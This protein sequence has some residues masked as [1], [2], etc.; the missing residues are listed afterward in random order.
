[1]MLNRCKYLFLASSAACAAVTNPALAQ[2]KVVTRP[3]GVIT[4]VS[5][6]SI[7]ARVA[8]RALSNGKVLVNDIVRRRVLLFDES[9]KSYKV[10]I[11]SAN[12]GG[13]NAAIPVSLPSAQLI[14]YTSDSTLY[15]DM[16]SMSLLVLDQTGKVAHVMA[17][18]RPRDAF[19]LGGGINFGTPAIDAKG[20]LV[21]RGVI[22]NLPKSLEPGATP[23]FSMPEQP[24]SAPIVRADFDTRKV[25]TLITMKVLKPGSMNMVTDKEGNMTMKITMNPVD[26]GDE[27]AMISDGSIAIVR[28]HDYHIDWLDTDGTRRSTAKMPF[29]WRR[30]TDERK[31]FMIDSLRPE[32]EKQ[33]TATSANLPMIPTAN[34]M[35]K[36]KIAFDFLPPAKMADYEPSVS[37]GAVRADL[38]NNVWILPRTAAGT[39]AGGV[40]YDVVNRLGEVTERVQ[41]PKGRALAGFGAGGVVYLLNTDGKS[42]LL[43]RALIR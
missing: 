30:L 9:L 8:I 34:G 15:V 3:I 5:A 43:E 13:S 22:V 10:V 17:L 41:L 40:V 28:A 1:M 14:R 16:S 6:D 12:S 24:D 2:Q 35:R 27:W 38:D 36:L 39:G 29:D 42:A 7:G 26:T 31:Q 20:R 25:D 21:Y 37:P 4:A 23:T 18:P 32:L 11:D 19:F 33:L